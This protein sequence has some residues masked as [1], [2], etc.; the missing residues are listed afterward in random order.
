MSDPDP[1]NEIRELKAVEIIHCRGHPN[2]TGTHRSTFEITKDPE[3][4]RTGTC[5]I[6]VSSDKGAKDL[7]DEF[8]KILSDERSELT[9]VFEVGGSHF[10]VRSF[11]SAGITLE[12]ETDLV[13][14]RSSFTCGRTVGIYSDCTAGQ[15]PRDIIKKIQEGTE[16]TVVLTARLNP[17]ARSPPVP[18]LPGIFHSFE[19]SPC[20]ACKD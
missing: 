13:W 2:V 16:I 3:V 5:I 17:E 4:S 6:G 19:E 14:R 9:A 1:C 12:H 10:Q 7:S 18:H 20:R 15:I 11:G 8:K